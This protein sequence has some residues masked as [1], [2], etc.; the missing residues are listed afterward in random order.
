LAVIQEAIVPT[1]YVFKCYYVFG[2]FV[3]RLN[4]QLDFE[5]R[6]KL[7]F[8]KEE[9]K[10]LIDAKID[11]VEHDIGLAFCQ[12]L[13]AVGFHNFGL[14]FV[15]RKGTNE[16]Y[17]FDINQDNFHWVKGVGASSG[18]RLRNGIERQFNP[19]HKVF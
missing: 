17:F 12:E 3:I 15:R 14:D 13:D 8:H 19:N 6:E 10:G 18:L 11:P 16:Y 9:V 5:N 2:H 7:T 1:D 4:N